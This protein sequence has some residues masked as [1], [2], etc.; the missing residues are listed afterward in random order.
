MNEVL[1][2]ISISFLT[3]AGLIIL[4][5][6]SLLPDSNFWE[7]ISYSYGLGF[8]LL[9]VQMF[10]YSRLNIN[11]NIYPLIIPWLI[12][13]LLV[14]SVKYKSISF[15]FNLNLKL[16]S[17][18]KLLLFLILILSIFVFFEAMVRPVL[19]WD[20]WASWFFKGKIFYLDGFVDPNV[21]KDMK[22]DYPLNI[23]LV[24]A[25][26]Y[27]I[28]GN[29]NDKLS[30]I[31][32][33]LFYLTLSTVF[34]FS[35]KRIVG[36][37]KAL[38]FTFLLMSI[39]NI[40]RHAGRYEAGQADIILGYYFFTSSIL[41][42]KYIE[43]KN[44]KILVLLSLFL[45]I[46]SQIKNEGIPFSIIIG[47]LILYQIL[48]YKLYKHTLLSL[49]WVLPI[50]DWQ[51]FKHVNHFPRNLF[52]N[53]GSIHLGRIVPNLIEFLK[54]AINIQNWSLL[55]IIFYLGFFFVLLGFNKNKIRLL[56]MIILAQLFIYFFM[57]LLM[58]LDP[59]IYYKNVTDRLYLHLA[60]LAVFSVGIIYNNLFGKY[61]KN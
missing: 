61:F 59:L 37:S 52:L 57:Y 48:K 7:E 21:L 40:I 55:W 18:D 33:P 24:V 46:V 19:A 54:E 60:P 11:W 38:L 14:F 58:P 47:V 27:T 34:F 2:L 29:I 6:F 10:I 31:I 22:A 51:L 20:G 16:K 44:V 49:F 50:I 15:K 42:I 28:L 30:L 17:Y 3:I 8:G 56:Y 41:L 53:N 5:G 43:T 39:Q 45:G 9:P 32:Y 13:C 23:S 26:I 12:F 36:I 25:F 4:K 1:I 35:I